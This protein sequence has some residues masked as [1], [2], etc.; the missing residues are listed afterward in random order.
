MQYSSVK[1]PRLLSKPVELIFQA[2]TIFHKN[3]SHSSILKIHSCSL[4]SSKYYTESTQIP[5][6]L[7]YIVQFEYRDRY[8][9]CVQIPQIL[10]Y[11]ACSLGNDVGI[12]IERQRIY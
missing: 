3:T 2:T 11:G 5:Q 7:E 12:A 4:A 9:K 1:K 10:V 6:L 8:T